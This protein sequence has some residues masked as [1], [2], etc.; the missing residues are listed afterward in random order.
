MS[1]SLPRRPVFKFTD[2]QWKSLATPLGLPIG[3]RAEL[4]STIDIFQRFRDSSAEQLSAGKMKKQLKAVSKKCDGLLRGMKGLDQRS[5]RALIGESDASHPTRARDGLDKFVER[6][7]QIL[8]LRKWCDLTV[9][10]TGA[11]A[12]GPAA[13]A[14]NLKWL[15]RG[16]GGVLMRHKNA[17]LRTTK[18]MISFVDEVCRIAAPSVG[19]RAIEPSR[20]RIRPTSLKDCVAHNMMPRSVMS[21]RHGAI[22]MP[23][24]NYSLE[25][26][27]ARTREYW[28]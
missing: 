28:R 7:E 6:Q 20:P 5:L 11:D 1:A 22:R 15:V 19:G 3:A 21:L 10:R 23:G 26:G 9:K 24:T 12:S 17:P 13:Q 25:C 14:E 8:A 4:Q 2:E 27:S 18:L 16:I